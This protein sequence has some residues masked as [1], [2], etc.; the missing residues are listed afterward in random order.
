MSKK[1]KFIF[2][3]IAFALAAIIVG[4]C[5][6]F[7]GNKPI[8]SLPE[9]LEV[10]KVEGEYFFVS[11]FNP[12]YHYQF[13]LEQ[14]IEEEFFT[15]GVV[16]SDVNT[17]K[18]EDHNLNIIA[19]GSYRFSVRYVN[20]NGGGKSKFLTSEPWSPSW[21]LDGVDY[22]DVTVID[23]TL[24]WKIVPDAE[25]Y[26]VVI[27]DEHL[28]K[29]EVET[30]ELSYSL[31]DLRAGQYTIYIIAQNSDK[32]I[33]SSEVGE[34]KQVVIERKNTLTNAHMSDG[35]L[36]VSSSYDVLKFE[37]YC[38]GTLLG[39]LDAG[40][41][42]NGVYVFE[43]CATLFDGVDVQISNIQIKSK[44]CGHVLESEFVIVSFS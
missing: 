9:T 7:F 10:Q 13:K 14:Y 44:K 29:K 24:S 20:E 17:I 12:E 35:D 8:K 16:N 18:L 33:N 32:F 38:D 42:K 1:Y 27:I 6:V 31:S 26:K 2:C 19:G 11:L 21:S 4:L 41:R 28:E 23:D 3:G 15:V 30:P 37:I 39:S 22:A 36:S 25:V 34:G 5:F 43:K 40:E